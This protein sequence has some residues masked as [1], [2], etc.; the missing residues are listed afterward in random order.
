MG[1][2]LTFTVKAEGK[3]REAILFL[4]AAALVAD[5]AEKPILKSY[6]AA[7]ERILIDDQGD[8]GLEPLTRKLGGI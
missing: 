7:L 2:V 1:D 6:I 5:E 8:A 3:I 4:K